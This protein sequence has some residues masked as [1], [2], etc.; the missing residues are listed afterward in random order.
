MNADEYLNQLK[1]ALKGFSAQETAVLVEEIRA[2]IEEGQADPQLGQAD[3]RGQKLQA[4]M[5]APGDLGRAFKEIYH[6]NRWVD[7]LLVFVPY[8]ILKY[9][10]NWALFMLFAGR[11]PSDTPVFS[12]PFM[13]AQIRVTIAFY[14]LFVLIALRRRSLPVLFF[15][16]PQ[17]ILS[18][19]VLVFR[20][21]RWLAAGAFNNSA[22]GILESA[23]WL[24]F[25]TGLV[26]WLGYCIW[27]QR[28]SSL[29]VVLAALPFLVTL[30]NLSLN[31]YLAGGLFPGGYALPMWHI[32]LF[33]GFPLG[34][35]QVSAI[36]WPLLFYLFP[37]RPVRWLGLLL[38]AVP[39]ALMNFVAS[40]RYPQLA[41]V[42]AIPILLVLAGWW[43]D[44]RM[45]PPRPGLT[46]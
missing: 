44:A 19:C 18:A 2:H 11:S 26:A 25:L 23:F 46:A 27:Q 40:L 15:W 8:E 36:T 45:H 13:L 41:A 28:R 9:P 14:A 22:A 16:L 21:K 29:L 10:I 1:T 33:G 5:G 12:D 7:F 24:V 30:G 31:P 4:E 37:Q 32:L 38:N 17:V 34:L 20:E 42:W 43:I 3:Q 35:Y 39:L 6:P